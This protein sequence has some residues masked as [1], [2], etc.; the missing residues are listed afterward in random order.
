MRISNLDW[1]D[2][3]IEYIAQHGAD[4]NAQIALVQM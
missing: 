2:Y 3:R 4:R 1:D